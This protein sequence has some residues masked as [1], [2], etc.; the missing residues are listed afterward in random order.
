MG[1]PHHKFHFLGKH[2]TR[3]R[4]SLELGFCPRGVTMGLV[5]EDGKPLGPAQVAPPEGQRSFTVEL[6]GPCQLPAGAVV[7]CVIDTECGLWTKDFPI[8]QRRGLQAFLYADARL[9]VESSEPIRAL[10]GE[11]RGRLS[12]LLPWLARAPEAPGCC[13]GGDDVLGMLR[14]VGVDVDELED[15]LREA[16]REAR[17]REQGQRR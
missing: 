3:W 15:G 4:V 17:P 6:S 5:S 11:E 16:L 1:A 13:G 12:E 14:E 9:P 2:E 10:S 7:R 8:D